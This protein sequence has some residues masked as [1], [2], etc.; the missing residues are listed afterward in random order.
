MNELLNNEYIHI[1]TD[2]LYKELWLNIQ[3]DQIYKSYIKPYG[4]LWTSFQNQYTISD[5]ISYKEDTC[6]QIELDMFYSLKSL[7]IK[8]KNNSKFISIEN[9]NDYKNLKDSNFVIELKQPIIINKWYYKEIINE[10]IN[11]EKL[12]LYYDLL[13]VNPIAYKTL[14]NYSIKTMY[15]LNADCIEYYKPTKIDYNNH[16]IISTGNKLQIEDNTKEY[17]LLK[18]Y[19][20]NLFIDFNIDNYN[21]YI[22]KLYEYQKEIIESLIKDNIPY[23]NN[24]P[25]KNDIIKTITKNIYRDIYLEK[26]KTLKLN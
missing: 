19:I 16:K 15:A 22:I 3:M 4:G 26:Q 9:E 11:Y 21:E 23:F 13:Y 17:Y 14:S 24:S 1:G 6:D 7:L 20:K 12:S 18:E 8:F 10:I 2:R 5:W 25:Y